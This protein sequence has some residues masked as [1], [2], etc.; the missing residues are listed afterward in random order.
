MIAVEKLK[1]A[2]E[3]K[4]Y[5]DEMD[6]AYKLFWGREGH[7]VEFRTVLK[8]WKNFAGNLKKDWAKWEASKTKASQTKIRAAAVPEEE[9]E[10]KKKSRRSSTGGP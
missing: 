6:T 1:C 4:A 9:E 7:Q 8:N 2:A 5:T 10:H 3:L